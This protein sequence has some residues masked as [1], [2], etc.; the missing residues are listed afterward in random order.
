MGR[1]LKYWGWGYEG[2][3]LNPDEIQNLL[4]SLAEF[5]ITGSEKGQFPTIDSISLDM[6]RLNLPKSLE[7]ICTTDKYERIL[8]TFGQSQPDSLRTFLGDFKNAPDIIAYP[9][10]ERDI[11]NLFEWCGEVNAAVIP[12]G[13]GSSVVG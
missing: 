2:T 4:K 8:H 12:Y 13:A 5:D 11:T 3:S 7:N 9:K 6:N 10:N 1:K